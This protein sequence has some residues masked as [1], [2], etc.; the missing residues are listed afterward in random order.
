MGWAMRAKKVVIIGAGGFAREAL[1]VF[2]AVNVVKPTYEVVGFV[3]DPEYGNPGNV[4]NG[5]PILG[6]FDWLEENTDVLGI[7]GVG[8]PEHRLKLIRRAEEIGIRFCTV[9]HPSAVLSRWL[10][11]G[12]GSIITAGCILGNQTTIGNHVH[13]N[14]DC[15]IGHDVVMADF[16]TLAP[17]A[18]VSGNVLMNEGCYVGTGANIVQKKT[19]GAWSI[20]GAGSTI[21]QDVP[22]NTTVVGVPGRV[23]KTREP[24]WHLT[25]S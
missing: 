22:A 11:I 13:L 21:T 5:K 24:G 15:T 16:V 4:V 17:G 8:A 2:D 14:A 12:E 23:I 20:I 18:H 3:V 19:I 25:S 10:R 7:C 1:D 9:I 6:G